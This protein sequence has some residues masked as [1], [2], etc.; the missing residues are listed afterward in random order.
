LTVRSGQ[1]A[2][3]QLPGGMV[4]ALLIPTSALSTLGQ[5]ERVFV[6]KDGRT[7]LRLVKTGAVH[8]ARVEVLSG[9]SDADQVVINPPAGMQE[10]QIVEVQP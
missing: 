5:M 1:F 10:G 8:G 2:R 3:V 7:V 4:R 6:N 9:L